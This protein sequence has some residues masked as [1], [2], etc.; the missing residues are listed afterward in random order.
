[1]MTHKIIRLPEVKQMTGLK[2]STIYQK[3]KIGEF[4]TTI[5]L[6]IRSVGWIEDEVQ[7]W[8]DQRINQS[9]NL[10]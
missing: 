1:M 2:R 6:S 9:R 10:I 3:M 5:G 8:I 4:P 7:A